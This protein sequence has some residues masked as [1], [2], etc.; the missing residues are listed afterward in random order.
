MWFKNLR[1]YRFTKPFEM[2][3]EELQSQLAE[4]AFHPCGRQDLSK[5]GWVPPIDQDSGS[6]AEPLYVHACNGY[7]MLCAKREDKVIPASVIKEA[8]QERSQHIE[9]KE[10]R[11][12]FKKEQDQLKDEVMLELLPRAFSKTQRVY[13]YISPKDDLL[14][15]DASS[16]AKAEQFMSHLRDTLGSLPVIPPASKQ[17][18]TDVMTHWL[19]EQS[20]H[21][22]FQLEKECEL[23]NPADSANVIRCKAQDLDAHEVQS[24]LESGKLCTKLAV[25]WND[26]L[27]CVIEDD[28]SIKRMKFDDQLIEQ[29][30]ETDADSKAQ[31]FD[32]D[33]AVM[34]LE[35]SKFC[36]DL[37][38]AFG[39]LEKTRVI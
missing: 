24:M 10:A 19:A 28:L 27:H 20:A 9:Q 2:G 14:L 39:G 5:Y 30:S 35:L 16:S 12:V 11:K 4:K 37:F 3:A 32:Q 25:N 33:F 13:A 34:S 31:Q 36:K 17:V 8:V 6:E 15:I 21:P 23:S 18:P 29:A 1:I 26:S 38:K 7:L 22:P